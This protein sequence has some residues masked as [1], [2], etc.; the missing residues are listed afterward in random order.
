MSLVPQ[1]D[2]E[3]IWVDEDIYWDFFG[4]VCESWYEGYHLH[5]PPIVGGICTHDSCWNL[6]CYNSERLGG[7]FNDNRS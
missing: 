4:P 3:E 7:W 5:W 2:L 1:V 6:M